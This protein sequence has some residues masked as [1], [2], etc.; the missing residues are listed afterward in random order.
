MSKYVKG[1]VQKQLE[2]AF[3]GVSE[4]MV[5]SIKGINGIDNNVMRGSLREKKIRLSVVKN[6]LAKNAYKNMGLK[7]SDG[8]FT[9][10]CATQ[11]PGNG[12]IPLAIAGNAITHP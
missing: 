3:S 2:K 11:G 5:V 4:F 8:L 12:N 9:G 10:P 6:S 1:L 7:V